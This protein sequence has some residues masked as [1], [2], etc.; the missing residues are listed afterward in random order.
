MFRKPDRPKGRITQCYNDGIARVYSVT[1][2]AAPGYQP[3]ETTVVKSVDHW[4]W[5]NFLIGGLIGFTIDS[6]D[7]HWSK[8]RPNE[9]DVALMPASER[10]KGS[11]TVPSDFEREDAVPAALDYASAGPN[12]ELD[13]LL[14]EVANENQKETK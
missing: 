12:P 1:D 2:S 7:G 6:V 5:G 3:V 10:S 14:D 13:A 9:W 11:G 4:I 8:C